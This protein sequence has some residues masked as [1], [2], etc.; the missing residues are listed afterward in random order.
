MD[1][2]V[3]GWCGYE[4]GILICK[5]TRCKNV[6][7]EKYQEDFLKE[8]NGLT[9]NIKRSFNE[10]SSS[11]PHSGSFKSLEATTFLEAYL[12]ILRESATCGKLY[13][14]FRKLSLQGRVLSGANGGVL[15][16]IWRVLKANK[17]GGRYSMADIPIRQQTIEICE[18]F[19]LDPYRLYA[20]GLVVWLCKEKETAILR[21]LC[22]DTEYPFALVGYT[23]NGSAIWRVDTKK[24]SSLRKP[25]MDE[26][27]KLFPCDKQC[28]PDQRN[29]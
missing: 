21:C 14:F 20:P 17:C 24:Q 10:R 28:F 1:I 2:V 4:G 29:L 19:G 6:L 11:Y 13:S 18:T 22:L 27:Y 8:E 5:D 12:P 7:L 25:A 23:T 9:L 15:S 3:T 16:A 26:L